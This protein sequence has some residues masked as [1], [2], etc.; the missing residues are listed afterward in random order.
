[1]TARTMSLKHHTKASLC[2][3]VV[4]CWSVVGCNAAMQ[5]RSASDESPSTQTPP[6]TQKN[7]PSNKMQPQ[8][9]KSAFG[10]T[11]AH[12]LNVVEYTNSVNDIFQLEMSFGQTLPRQT[13]GDGFLNN[14]GKIIMAPG[15]MEDYLKAAQTITASIWSTPTAKAHLLASCEGPQDKACAQ[16]VVET[17]LPRIWRGKHTDEDKQLLMG[18]FDEAQQKG[19]GFEDSLSMMLH[20]ALLSPKFLFRTYSVEDNG[21]VR[22]LTDLELATKLAY[23]LWSSTPDDALLALAKDNKLSQPE[24]LEAQVERM[25]TDDQARYGALGQ[26]YFEAWLGIDKLRARG[27]DVDQVQASLAESTR[28]FW[29]VL[30]EDRPFHEL[31]TAD[32]MFIN[33]GNADFYGYAVPNDA[34]WNQVDIDLQIQ[35]PRR[36][37][38]GQRAFLKRYA[39]VVFRGVAINKHILCT[40]LHVALPDD[41]IEKLG[42]QSKQL[43]SGEISELTSIQQRREDPS[44]TGCHSQIDSA[45]YSLFQFDNTGVFRT[46]DEKGKPINPNVV[47][48]ESV[49]YP[50]G[51]DYLE[52]FKD[53]PRV[54]KCMVRRTLGYATGRTI[55]YIEDGAVEAIWQQ[56]KDK[57]TGLRTLLKTIATSEAFQTRDPTNIVMLNTG[58][59]EDK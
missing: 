10:A 31:L 23:F 17:F 40:D 6:K 35:G 16:S 32:Y 24:T 48:S 45:G 42:E 50:N 46:E 28:L 47:L 14:A 29:H 26:Q 1:M 9:P 13:P 30:S 5:A 44:C 37:V 22:R 18:L 11:V 4:L 43:V 58:K 20:A 56:W 52:T 27:S 57:G 25:L 33:Q 7:Q 3:L 12:R 59:G 38:L 39:G 34:N 15:D 55:K 21:E 36:G 53:N 49:S 8:T 19:I 2:L 51:A 54:E 41:V